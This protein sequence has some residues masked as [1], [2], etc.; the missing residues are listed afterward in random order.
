ME[1]AHRFYRGLGFTRDPALDWSPV[2]GVELV[3]FRLD[4]QE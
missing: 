2:T 3:A 4:L 1:A